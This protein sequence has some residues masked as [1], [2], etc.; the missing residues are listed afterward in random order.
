M[1]KTKETEVTKWDEMTEEE[2]TQVLVELSDTTAWQAILKYFSIRST[3]TDD[4]LRSIDPFKEPT[5]MARNQGIRAGLW[6]IVLYV[7]SEIDRRKKKNK[8]EEEN[9]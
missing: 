5:Q 3:S 9:K 1:K 6:D 2:M 4:G 7:N 8:E